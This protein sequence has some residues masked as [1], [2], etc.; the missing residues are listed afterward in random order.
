V[1][2]VYAV[3]AYILYLTEVVPNEL[4]EANTRILAV[5]ILAGASAR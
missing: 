2:Q 3:T 4:Q 5:W 1:A